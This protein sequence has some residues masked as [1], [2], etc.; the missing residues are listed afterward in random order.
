[1]SNGVRILHHQVAM[2]ALPR[3]IN[4]SGPRFRIKRPHGTPGDRLNR[5]DRGPAPK[6]T[7]SGRRGKGHIVLPDA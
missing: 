2:L 6:P 1:M 4:Q 5:V 3:R 7:D